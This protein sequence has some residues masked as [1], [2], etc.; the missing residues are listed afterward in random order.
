MKGVIFLVVAC[1]MLAM[2]PRVDASAQSNYSV[3]NESISAGGTTGAS[4][5]FRATTLMAEPMGTEGTSPNFAIVVPI[6]ET[7]VGLPTGIRSVPHLHFSLFIL[8]LSTLNIFLLIKIPL[9]EGQ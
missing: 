4:P 9:Q 6:P 2:L 8:L 7:I 1:G 5:N 3:R